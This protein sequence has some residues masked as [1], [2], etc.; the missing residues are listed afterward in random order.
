MLNIITKNLVENIAYN[1]NYEFGENINNKVNN[2]MS[3]AI[4]D[5]S[6]KNPYIKLDSCLFQPINETFNGAYIPGSHYEYYIGFMSPQIELN[7]LSYSNWWSKFRKRFKEAWVSSS[8][9]LT[10]KREKRIKAGIVEEKP[11]EIGYEKYTIE[12][13]LEDL[14]DS[15][16]KYLTNS[17]IVYKGSRTLRIIGKEEFGSNTEIIIHPVIVEGTQYKYFINKKKGFVI[18][19]YTT[20][21]QCANEKFDKLGENYLYML[22][23]FNHFMR[24]FTKQPTNQIFLESIMY[25]L[26]EEFIKG[27]DLYKNFIKA[28]NYL[29]AQDISDYTSVMDLNKKIFDEKSTAN[30]GFNYSK[31]L[32]SFDKTKLEIVK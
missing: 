16:V 32:K 18:Y 19:D 4:Q 6:Q 22:K 12:N 3:L 24:E 23:I 21:A 8:R 15:C 30:Y 10:K 28:I 27:K 29:R 13:L 5:L 20:R 31:F 11:L 26:P 14:Q 17:S 2:L 9:R 7:S 1:D 25:N